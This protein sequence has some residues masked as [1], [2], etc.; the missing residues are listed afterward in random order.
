MNIAVCVKQIP[1]PAV[2]GKLD[3][4]HTL[5]RAGK[6]HPRR[7]RHLRRRDGAAARRQGRRRRGHPHL[8]GAQRR[9]VGPAHRAG[10]G[11][12]PGR[13]RVRRRARRLRRAVHGQGARQGGRARR[14]RRPRASPRPSRPTAT[15]ARS[16]RRSPSCSAG[17]RSRSPSTSRSATA[18]S[19]SSARPRR[20]TTRSRRSL[21]AV[22]SVT[23]GV[24]EPR[25][26][27]FK[28]IMAAKNKPV[29]Q[30]TV[31]DLG[32]GADAGR[33]GRCPPEDRVR[34]APRPSGEAGEKI[35]DDGEAYERIVAVPRAAQGR[36]TVHGRRFAELHAGDSRRYDG[37]FQDL[38]VR[39][40]RRRQAHG[41]DARA[42]HQGP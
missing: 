6:L 19:P 40:G 5:D 28:G 7:L 17:R 14:R 35:E 27:S 42:A 22:V 4:D 8:D 18:R 12:G 16:P 34:S 31:A 33:L 2:P 25:Y 26:P 15:P 29:D 13:A 36:L 20:A 39:R 1:D 41:D 37:S 11:R 30:V 24:V 38:G 9:G 32:L 10:H 23:A 21:P 3:A